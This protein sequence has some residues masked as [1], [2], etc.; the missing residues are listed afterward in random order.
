M[1]GTF[2]ASGAW[3]DKTLSL[4][5]FGAFCLLLQEMWIFF[6]LA[7]NWWGRRKEKRA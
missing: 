3:C 2:Y 5:A 4:L 7:S 6:S 1:C